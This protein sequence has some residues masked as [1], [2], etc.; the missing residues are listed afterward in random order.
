MFEFGVMHKLCDKRS[1]IE[2]AVIGADFIITAVDGYPVNRRDHGL[3]VTRVPLALIEPGDRV[4]T[5]I[6]N[7]GVVHAADE[8]KVFELE[9]EILQGV[10]YRLFDSEDGVPRLVVVD[11]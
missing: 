2:D 4:L 1:V 8:V 9:E 7:E 10:R 6:R 11:F 5:I 3:F